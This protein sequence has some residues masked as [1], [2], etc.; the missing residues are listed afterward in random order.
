METVL[1]ED[2]LNVTQLRTETDGECK[3][4]TISRSAN[5]WR[6]SKGAELCTYIQY[7][8]PSSTI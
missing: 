7:A 6:K 4:D 5:T 8:L 3:A 1:Q 2:M